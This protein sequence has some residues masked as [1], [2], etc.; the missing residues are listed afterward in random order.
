LCPLIFTPI[1]KADDGFRFPEARHGKGQLKYHQELP[2]LVV[3]GSP[4]EIGE[5]I[6]VLAVKP[7]AAEYKVLVQKNTDRLGPAL[8][9]LFDLTERLFK[10][11][12][13]TL[14]LKPLFKRDSR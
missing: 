8:P 5:Q 13:T 4:R 11:P 1:A 6:G 9:L 2:V 12:L 3:E 7:I 14:E 10:A